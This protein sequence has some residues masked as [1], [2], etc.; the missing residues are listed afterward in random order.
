MK[1]FVTL[2]LILSVSVFSIG[3]GGDDGGKKKTDDKKSESKE[4]TG[5]EE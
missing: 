4:K 5:E 1:K 2:M 3:C